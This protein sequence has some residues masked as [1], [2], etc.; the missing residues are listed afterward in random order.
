[1]NYRLEVSPQAQAEIKRLPGH[2]RQRVRRVIQSFANDP[3]PP[4]SKTL[5]FPLPAAEPRR[6]SLG[7][8]RIVYVISETDVRWIAVVAVRKRPPYD[9]AD[10]ADLFADLTR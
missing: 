1:M 10:L 5:D 8:W 3:R 4:H 9:Y 6:Y 7:C 2:V